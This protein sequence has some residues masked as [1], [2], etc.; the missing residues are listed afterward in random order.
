MF[1]SLYQPDID[2][3][4]KH[5]K[6]YRFGFNILFYVFG[7]FLLIFNIGLSTS[8]LNAYN[9]EE[10]GVKV[11]DFSAYK[12]I[13]KCNYS[14]TAK[15][16][17]GEVE[18]SD[19]YT[20]NCITLQS[21]NIADNNYSYLKTNDFLN[22]VEYYVY[23]E[24]SDIKGNGHFIYHDSAF[25]TTINGTLYNGNTIYNKGDY[26]YLKDINHWDFYEI[27]KFVPNWLNDN[28]FI[29]N[30]VSNGNLYYS[31]PN[32]D[33]SYY[34]YNTNGDLTVY[35]Q[36]SVIDKINIEYLYN[37]GNKIWYDNDNTENAYY[38]DYI[39]LTDIKQAQ[40][41]LQQY[42][43]THNDTDFN[44]I[45]Y[46]EEGFDSSSYYKDGIFYLWDETD[47]QFYSYTIAEATS[48]GWISENDVVSYKEKGNTII[49]TNN[50]RKLISDMKKHREYI[51]STYKLTSSTT[52]S[53]GTTT[54]TY[55]APTSNSNSYTY[56]VIDE[57]PVSFDA[58]YNYDF[59][60]VSE[61]MYQYQTLYSR[62]Q[63]S[64]SVVDQKKTETQTETWTYALKQTESNKTTG[65]P[66]SGYSII[67]SAN[68]L[69][70]KG[71][72]YYTVTN[73]D[74]Y[75]LTGSYKQ[76]TVQTGDF[77]GWV[78][79]N[80]LYNGTTSKETVT[81]THVPDYASGYTVYK[82]SGNNYYYETS[83]NGTQ[84]IQKI[85]ATQYKIQ[86]TKN[87]TV[88]STNSNAYSE[89]SV[90]LSTVT[91]G[92]VFYTNKTS[93]VL[94][95]ATGRKYYNV[96]YNKIS[97]TSSVI[98]NG[99]NAFSNIVG[100]KSS[101]LSTGK[102]FYIRQHSNSSGYASFTYKIYTRVQVLKFGS[103]CESYGDHSKYY[104]RLTAINTGMA[105]KDSYTNGSSHSNWDYPI[106]M[107]SYE[108]SGW[109]EITKELYDAVSYKTDD[110]VSSQLITK[111]KG[112]AVDIPTGSV[113]H[114][115]GFWNGWKDYGRVLEVKDGYIYNSSNFTT[116]T[117]NNLG[118]KITIQGGTKSVKKYYSTL[119]SA[120][121]KDSSKYTDNPYNYEES[122][123]ERYN[124]NSD[125]KAY[126][127][128]VTSNV[129]KT[130][131]YTYTKYTVQSGLSGT[132]S[133]L[134][135]KPSKG[136]YFNNNSDTYIT[137]SDDGWNETQKVTHYYWDK[138][139]V[140]ITSERIKNNEDTGY[141]YITSDTK[142]YLYED[143]KYIGMDVS[144][145]LHTKLINKYIGS[146]TKVSD[147]QS[148][149]TFT[150]ISEKNYTS[151]ASEITAY[152]TVY[153]Y[154]NST[155]STFKQYNSISKKL[156]NAITI[157]GS[158]FTEQTISSLITNLKGKLTDTVSNITWNDQT[159]QFDITYKPGVNSS[160]ANI[161]L[162][163]SSNYKTYTYY[164][165]YETGNTDNQSTGSYSDI[166][167][168]RKEY[169]DTKSKGNEYF[170]NQVD[171]Q[172]SSAN[173]TYSDTNKGTINIKTVKTV[174]TT[175]T[176]TRTK[177]TFDGTFKETSDTVTLYNS[178]QNPQD[179]S[180]NNFKGYNKNYYV[181]NGVVKNDGT[182]TT[183]TEC[184]TSSTG[185]CYKIKTK[186]NQN[187]EEIYANKTPYETSVTYKESNGQKED[188]DFSETS[189]NKAHYS[190]HL[191][192]VNN[193]RLC[194]S[195]TDVQCYIFVSSSYSSTPRYNY[196]KNVVS[197]NKVLDKTLTI[198]YDK[199]SNNSSK[200]TYEEFGVVN[201][202]TYYNDGRIVGG[203]YTKNSTTGGIS[204]LNRFDEMSFFLSS[205]SLLKKL[206][207]D[208]GFNFKGDN[209]TGSVNVNGLE[210]GS[211]YTISFMAK[212]E[213]G[214]ATSINVYVDNNSVSGGQ[215][216]LTN[217]Y[218]KY[219]YTFKATS[220]SATISFGVSGDAT[221]KEIFVKEGTTNLSYTPYAT[222]ALGD[223]TA[224]FYEIHPITV[225][226][227]YYDVLQV[228]DN[229]GFDLMVY[230][231][232]SSYILQSITP[233]NIE[234]EKVEIVKAN[235]NGSLNLNNVYMGYDFDKSG[236][237]ETDE[238]Y[239][240]KNITDVFCAKTENGAC[241]Y[242]YVYTGSLSNPLK[243]ERTRTVT[244]TFISTSEYLNKA[245]MRSMTDSNTD[246]NV[247]L[248][249][250]NQNGSY[251]ESDPTTYVQSG[252]NKFSIDSLAGKYFLLK[253]TLDSKE[254][255]YFDIS[256]GKTYV[257][258]DGN[259]KYK[260][261]IYY[262]A[263]KTLLD[264][265][266]GEHI[267]LDKG[268]TK[269]LVAKHEYSNALNGI[270][271][272]SNY[273]FV[274]IK[275]IIN[276]NPK[277]ERYKLTQ[278]RLYELYLNDNADF[279]ITITPK[280]PQNP[281]D[282]S[283]E[284]YIFE[285]DI[286]S[287][288]PTLDDFRNGY[289]V[290]NSNPYGLVIDSNLWDSN[291]ERFTY[292]GGTYKFV[293]TSD[294]TLGFTEFQEYY[295]GGR[296]IAKSIAEIFTSING[297]YDLLDK[298][299]LYN[300]GSTNA[301]ENVTEIY[302]IGG[303]YYLKDMY[304]Y[305]IENK[306]VDTT[307]DFYSNDKNQKYFYVWASPET[308]TDSI[309]NKNPY[310][311]ITSISLSTVVDKILTPNT[312]IVPGVSIFTQYYQVK[313][314]GEYV[315]FAIN[316]IFSLISNNI[317]IYKLQQKT[318]DIKVNNFL[319][320][321]DLEELDLSSSSI[322]DVLA[323][324]SK[325][326]SLKFT[327]MMNYWDGTLNGEKLYDKLSL[328]GSTQY[329]FNNDPERYNNKDSSIMFGDDKVSEFI[330]MNKGT[331]KN[332]AANYDLYA[333]DQVYDKGKY[334]DIK[335]II[336]DL[337][338]V[339][340]VLYQAGYYGYMFRFAPS[341]YD[342]NT[343]IKEINSVT[344][345]TNDLIDWENAVYRGQDYLKRVFAS[346]SY[347]NII[348][349]GN[350]APT[351]YNA[352]SDFMSGGKYEQYYR[353]AYQ[354]FMTYSIL[355]PFMTAD[356][357]INDL[358]YM[359]LFDTKTLNN[360][361]YKGTAPFSE[362]W[363]EK[364]YPNSTNVSSTNMSI[365]TYK[366]FNSP[367]SDYNNGIFNSDND[368]ND[369]YFAAAIEYFLTAI[370][371]SNANW[372]NLRFAYSNPFGTV[373]DPYS[374]WQEGFVVD[375]TNTAGGK[376]KRNVADINYDMFNSNSKFLDQYSKY[377][378]KYTDNKSTIEYERSGGTAFKLTDLFNALPAL[379]YSSDL[380]EEY[381]KVLEQILNKTSDVGVDEIRLDNLLDYVQ[382]HT[383]TDE[384]VFVRSN[385]YD[386]RIYI[387]TKVESD[388]LSPFTVIRN[389][390]NGLELKG[391][392]FDYGYSSPLVINGFE[393][394]T[395]NTIVGEKINDNDLM[396]FN[397]YMLYKATAYNGHEI[398]MDHTYNATYSDAEDGIYIYGVTSVMTEAH[399][400]QN[401]RNISEYLSQ[402]MKDMIYNKN[403]FK[404]STIL[405]LANYINDE[406]YDDEY[407]Y[408]KPEIFISDVVDNYELT[409]NETWTKNYTNKLYNTQNDFVMFSVTSYDIVY[410]S[411]LPME[412]F[413]EFN[414]SRKIITPF[415]LMEQLS[416]IDN[417]KKSSAMYTLSS[418]L[419]QHNA[420]FNDEDTRYHLYGYFTNVT[421]NYTNDVNN[422]LNTYNQDNTPVNITDYENLLLNYYSITSNDFDN[423]FYSNKAS[424][425]T[426][427][428]DNAHDI[429]ISNNYNY[430]TV[431]NSYAKLMNIDILGQ[432][433]EKAYDS[434]EIAN[435]NTSANL[436]MNITDDTEYGFNRTNF[437]VQIN[438]D[439][440]KSTYNNSNISQASTYE[441][442][443]YYTPEYETCSSGFFFDNKSGKCF[444]DNTN[445]DASGYEAFKIYDQ[446]R[447]H[448]T[449]ENAN[450]QIVD[451]YTSSNLIENITDEMI[452][453]AFNLSS[454]TID[455]DNYKIIY[456]GNENYYWNIGKVDTDTILTNLPQ[457]T[458]LTLEI[459]QR[460][461]SGYIT[462]SFKKEFTT[463]LDMITN[464][465]GTTL[466]GKIETNN[467]DDKLLENL[468]IPYD[469]QQ[470]LFTYDGNK[471]SSTGTSVI[472]A[473]DGKTKWTISNRY[474]L[475]L[476]ANTTM[477]FGFA[478]VN[479]KTNELFKLNDVN[480]WIRFKKGVDNNQYHD[481]VDLKL[482]N[483][484]F[485]F[486]MTEKEQTYYLENYNDNPNGYLKEVILK[487][488]I[489]EVSSA[490][491]KALNEN[492]V[493]QLKAI[494]YHEDQYLYFDYNQNGI[495]DEELQTGGNPYYNDKGMPA[496]EELYEETP[497]IKENL[498][499]GT[500]NITSWY[501]C[502]MSNF[503]E[504]KVG[505][506][507]NDYYLFAYNRENGSHIVK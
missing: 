464:P 9:N 476:S 211:T 327:G 28:R 443:L 349:D 248:K 451:I 311:V 366:L 493:Y 398:F 444:Y 335:D 299:G 463:G 446:N 266:T 57:K 204:S 252:Q 489:I 303:K 499:I 385:N 148:G 159:K 10:S 188:K 76:A 263:N 449:V 45:K 380:G 428:L 469:L 352:T 214:T 410:G 163:L 156:G 318:E 500:N 15:D 302:K 283:V 230:T 219:T 267:K 98:G 65:G 232:V 284:N 101:G 402:L 492:N 87:E 391:E 453:R 222:Y 320:L 477:G 353:E 123:D 404:Y 206:A 198:D 257:L 73:H 116:N 432:T 122:K 144:S 160:E 359:N 96:T 121:S 468:Y 176:W 216:D 208:G 442:T 1:R 221:F 138:Y 95:E 124:L 427:R 356:D 213:N 70:G 145:T 309:Y 201:G 418:S 97:G 37:D 207:S 38:N 29:Y 447:Y 338:D 377:N 314:D 146:N 17:S 235:E 200:N 226:L 390:V 137:N 199:S 321:S 496:F 209:K 43:Q 177:H 227:S 261:N 272:N 147:S 301:N 103:L 270:L 83:T 170:T 455:R 125:Y 187:G 49:S 190:N 250:G 297:N 89:G 506:Y 77:V 305:I 287:Y 396:S 212:L 19:D 8:P 457:S 281:G 481:T 310:K 111:L 182:W 131:D 423:Y 350:S 172:K 452:I 52:T 91:N 130:Y 6:K 158:E 119:S 157:N 277:G 236:T 4:L 44:G 168:V 371:D 300:N 403:T 364:Y 133:A 234:N 434:D 253:E 357:G 23:E 93:K 295:F 181:S 269:K 393:S 289:V 106:S 255:F 140:N 486:I 174:I 203:T 82:D 74:T 342:A 100:S 414:S 399:T 54:E 291:F 412:Y 308:I 132:T 109:H 460:V 431:D 411:I 231:D 495:Y 405:T 381:Y 285:Y 345:G 40:Y 278:E 34:Q 85:N 56:Y 400:I 346:S 282:L 395:Y 129:S 150:T 86:I 296:W 354:Q 332:S 474:R 348:Y 113:L 339:M 276:I 35:N 337:I 13:D 63:Y 183:L 264:E 401:I 293:K 26:S 436:T 482:E 241:V 92:K 279:S 50:E 246:T 42:T 71:Q 193:R 88:E 30:N 31:L 329:V 112:T 483:G 105:S 205:T 478:L 313:I 475:Q 435:S 185:V 409:V 102:D 171:D 280:N 135:S 416:T 36:Y 347:A 456:V 142:N 189:G 115:H 152:K 363:N 344:S 358:L 323:G 333:L 387:Y 94:D 7:L 290:E 118:N 153:T 233:N 504:F 215:V 218:V 79:N 47:K 467:N 25:D 238:Q 175:H 192:T 317:Y 80:T 378:W 2:D 445:I 262:D 494:T 39:T 197:Y 224:N 376:F 392:D 46:G 374:T 127:M 110:N 244:A 67:T 420:Y 191:P 330:I 32:P 325:N 319:Y 72:K 180:F 11:E 275:N 256:T 162:T 78:L 426:I 471:P 498:D 368:R 12:S 20:L 383:K 41:K 286:N 384:Y 505:K 466:K 225:E 419:E 450:K 134:Y 75:D 104:I 375:T 388:T 24:A 245:N 273:D 437:S 415:P 361:S 239:S 173:P 184:S 33:D 324:S 334:Y 136:D 202:A 458:T 430:I 194:E 114:S 220:T 360:K 406:K 16:G 331:N 274:D 417:I 217:S 470:G 240:I 322:D 355:G 465:Y 254:N 258:R 186:A 22:E 379:Q 485:K 497:F 64:F 407:L 55:I 369:P 288:T 316:D 425:Q 59:V 461:G 179:T 370:N 312:S 439:S 166:S 259:D 61:K 480:Y 307:N 438:K 462:K 389:N 507:K 178:S 14:L 503:D 488:Y 326:Y 99:T 164:E 394:E 27:Y 479:T 487:D 343:L 386:D 491:Y 459:R 66:E 120:P 229:G 306:N 161:S 372:D 149:K 422:F 247:I 373:L 341:G 117:Y 315:D 151:V 340:N 51:E 294:E 155:G 249:Y 397:R 271:N 440:V 292:N 304:L 48:L 143:Q 69:T 362:E 448:F 167:S 195:D 108:K 298:N 21:Q 62:Y 18:I 413:K 60:Y 265:E 237:I 490:L 154:S 196:E 328:N 367:Y 382:N 408:E 441:Y 68:S 433:Y 126:L 472:T 141:F 424:Y 210:I 429:F 165:S 501:T 268:F 5:D 502:V 484:V 228:E 81:L 243:Y 421:N 3:T 90:N 84:Y 53:N 107:E 260:Y 223:I 473:S 169:L 58:S 351:R 242:R 128:I 454:N 336:N 365:T 139:T 251:D